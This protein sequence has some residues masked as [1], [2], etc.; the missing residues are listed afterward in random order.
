MPI[1]EVSL[2]CPTGWVDELGTDR[3]RLTMGSWSWV[4]LARRYAS[5]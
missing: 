4:A 5:A 2:T 3:C 1:A